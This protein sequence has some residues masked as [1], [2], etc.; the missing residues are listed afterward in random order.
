LVTKDLFGHLWVG[1]AQRVGKGLLKV[2][3]GIVI[4]VEHI[5]VVCGTDIKDGALQGYGVGMVGVCHGPCRL[6]TT[7]GG[8]VGSGSWLT[9]GLSLASARHGQQCQQ[10]I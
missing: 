9:I 8:V 6:V 5:Q 10:D 3:G 4:A 1:T 2:L 7:A